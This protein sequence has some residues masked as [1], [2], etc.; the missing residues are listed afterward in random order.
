MQGYPPSLLPWPIDIE[1]GWKKIAGFFSGEAPLPKTRNTGTSV[2]AGCWVT[3]TRHHARVRAR[4]S[5]SLVLNVDI[6]F[7]VY[8][9]LPETLLIV[10]VL[11]AYLHKLLLN[12]TPPK[13]LI[14]S[15]KFTLLSQRLIRFKK[16][17]SALVFLAELLSRF[18]VF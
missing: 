11:R 17:M 13:K 3:S 12:N 15:G 5:S 9:I 4:V 8:P 16:T 7:G 14:I 2:C 1:A 10:I 6:L 18:C